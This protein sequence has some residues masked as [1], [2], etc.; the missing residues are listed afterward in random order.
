MKKKKKR[1]DRICI[2]RCIET[3]KDGSI[4]ETVFYAQRHSRGA[5]INRVARTGDA[6]FVSENRFYRHTRSGLC[7]NV[8]ILESVFFFFF[9]S[10]IFFP[11]SPSPS[12]PPPPPPC[13]VA[14]GPAYLRSTRAMRKKLEMHLFI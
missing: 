4:L 2:S 6:S 13:F 10:L 12:P 7:A 1:K 5:L 14:R 8:F 11:P 3:E 9:P